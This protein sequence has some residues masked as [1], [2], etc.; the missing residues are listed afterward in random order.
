MTELTAKRLRACMDY[1]PE[2]GAFSWLDTQRAGH[3]AGC[4]TKDG[5]WQIR[6]EGR[7]YYAHRLAWLYVRGE[8]PSSHLDHRDGDRS[9]NAI[10]NLRLASVAENAQNRLA[11]RNNKTGYLG[12]CKRGRSYIAQ[13]QAYG[14]HVILG[15]RDDPAEAHALYLAAKANLHSFQ[16][17]P[18][19][20]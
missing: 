7:S 14:V 5:Y 8:W 10:S 6:F 13:I 19:A 9:H 12:V 15:Y 2:T 3:I 4:K 16:P 18:R 1:D 17:T 20:A 11:Q